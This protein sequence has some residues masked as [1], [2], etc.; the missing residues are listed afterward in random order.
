MGEPAAPKCKGNTASAGGEKGQDKENEDME[1]EKCSSSQQRSME[2]EVE[3]DDPAST[4]R[5]GK[6]GRGK[7]TPLWGSRR[8]DTRGQ[9]T[10]TP[11]GSARGN[12]AEG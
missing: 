6:G 7:A 3:T 12:F 9:Q 11:L 8:N 10:R 2:I 4:N 1:D 5:G